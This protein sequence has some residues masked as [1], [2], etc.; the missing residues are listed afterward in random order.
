M[1]KKRTIYNIAKELNLAPGTIS[2]VINQTGNVSAKTRERVLAYIKEVGYVPN[3]SARMLKSKRTYTVGIVFTEESDVGLEHSF[4]SSILQHFKTYV[5][6]QGYELSF[7]VKKLGQHELS[8]LEWC[9]NKRVDGVYIVVGNYNDKGLYDLINSPIPA[10]STDMLVPGLHTVVSDNELGMKLIFDFINNELDAKK[11]AFISGPKT[12]KAF[13]ERVDAYQKLVQ[14]YQMENVADITYA[15]SFG[16]TSGYNAAQELIKSTKNR[17]ECILVASDD[18]ALGVLKGLKDLGINIPE[19]I[20]VIGFDDIAFAKH[21]T[22]SLTTIRQDRKELGER[23]A[24]LLLE[25]IEN[26]D[27][28]IEEVVKLPVELIVRESTRKK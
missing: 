27:E 25:L 14:T 26:P 10:V 1:T 20:S 8:Y 4:F 21:F 22:P 24:K 2:K 5:E 11:L 23:A 15:E 28:E 13:N 3:N 12:S 7:I 18:I 17:P 16:F 19:D 6:L 9:M